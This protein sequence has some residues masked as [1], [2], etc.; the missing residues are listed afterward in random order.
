MEV[1]GPPRRLHAGLTTRQLVAA[2]IVIALVVI[3]AI[4][5]LGGD[6]DGG[7]ETIKGPPDDEFS[8]LKPDGWEEVS[9]DELALIPGK[10]LAVL[11]RGE[12]EGLVT[13]TAPTKAGSNIEDAAAELDKRL[14]KALPDFRKVSARIVEVQ[15]GRALLYSYVRTKKATAHTI[16][17]VPGPERTYTVN[18]VVPAGAEDAARDVGEILNSFDV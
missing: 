4:V 12:G 10:P 9:G 17:V 14:S 2:A 7:A 3:G 5:L 1:E 13:V 16:L 6:D 18:A 15:A 8:L 11:R